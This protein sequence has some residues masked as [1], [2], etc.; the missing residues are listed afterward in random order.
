[1]AV[2]HFFFVFFVFVETHRKQTVIFAEDKSGTRKYFSQKT[3]IQETDKFVL[4]KSGTLNQ[5]HSITVPAVVLKR[6]TTKIT[7]DIKPF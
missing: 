3:D 5:E 4:D 7:P 6:Y 2:F 1:M